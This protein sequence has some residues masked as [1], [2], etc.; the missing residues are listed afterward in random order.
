MS[1][2][3]RDEH[4]HDHLRFRV[5]KRLERALAWLDLLKPEYGDLG[6]HRSRYTVFGSVRDRDDFESRWGNIQER[7]HRQ[8][9]EKTLADGGS[10]K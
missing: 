2:I 10:D 6:Y 1:P 5:V 7:R 8:N 4:P 3:G 9:V